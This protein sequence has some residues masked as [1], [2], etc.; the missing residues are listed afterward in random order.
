MRE[1]IY[2]VVSRLRAE[3][4]PLSRNRHFHAFQA[5]ETRA[6]LRIDRR[7]RS[8]ERDLVGRGEAR[9]TMRRL[10]GGDVEVTVRLPA[11]SAVRVARVSSEELELLLEEDAVRAALEPA[12]AMCGGVGLDPR[13]GGE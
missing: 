11:L 5:P 12:L 10:G 8:L 3:G 1:F 4:R 7:L 6:A 13:Q 9:V 2:R